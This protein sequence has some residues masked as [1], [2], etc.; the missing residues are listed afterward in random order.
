MKNLFKKIGALLVAAVMVLSMCTAVFAD[1]GT[2]VNYPTASDT[3]EIKV[4]NVEAG[5]TVTAY[6]VVE[7]VYI[8]DVGFE[9]YQTV[10]GV[11]IANPEKPTAAEITSIAAKIANGTL[12]GLTSVTLS[13]DAT[14]GT[15]YK[16][17][18]GAGYWVVLVTG[19]PTAS[20]V[21]NPMLAGVY[22][23]VSGSDKATEGGSIDASQKWKLNDATAHDKSVDVSVEKVI[24]N[25]TGKLTSDVATN[26][27]DDLAIGDYAKFKVTGTIPAYTDAYT[28][29]TY[30]I[31]DTLAGGLK[32]ENTKDHPIKVTV[33]GSDVEKSNYTLTLSEDGKSIVVDFK[34]A[35]ALE[36]KGQQVVLTYDAQLTDTALTNF[37]PNTN[38]VKVTYTNDP[39][40]DKETGKAPTTDTPEK[41]T[42]HYTFELDGKLYGNGTTTGEKTTTEITKTGNKE[43]KTDNWTLTENG[44]LSGAEF[45]LTRT[46][47]VDGTKYVYVQESDANGA[48]HFKG[49]DAGTYELKETKAPANYTLNSATIPV[50]IT[51]KYNEDGTLNSYS[52]NINRKDGKTFTYTATYNN[53]VVQNVELDTNSTGTF[54]IKNTQISSLPSTGGMG[55]YLFTIIGVVVMAGAAGAFFISRRK[56][57]EE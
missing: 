26:K 36:H 8:T 16:A 28:N 30:K 3:A 44:P 1:E 4:E 33:G 55:T 14:N 46:D 15:V 53:K 24:T 5:A 7:P 49:L 38:T 57:S 47:K 42:Y 45:T 10:T 11:N 18:A 9:K 39:T 25:S 23:S 56:G 29:V 22:Y 35:Y 37:N 48:L 41:K 6:R 31:T 32:A 21:Y 51:A 40:I 43:T 27:G 19:I 12:T 20:K 13:P 17:E 34:S 50:V 54:E 52:V 2:K